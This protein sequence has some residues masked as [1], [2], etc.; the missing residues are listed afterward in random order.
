MSKVN[1]QFEMEDF[2]KLLKGATKGLEELKQRAMLEAMDREIKWKREKEKT[3]RSNIR[4]PDPERPCIYKIDDI[5]SDDEK[6][7]I[8]WNM[9]PSKITLKDIIDQCTSISCKECPFTI[10]PHTSRYGLY[11]C[12]LEYKDKY[13]YR[14]A[15][16]DWEDEDENDPNMKPT[17]ITPIDIIKQC[18]TMPCDECPFGIRIKECHPDIFSPKYSCGLKYKGK[19]IYRLGWVTNRYNDGSWEDDDE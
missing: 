13:I 8:T 12:G 11:K 9:K 14:Y 15:E 19:H 5:D 4:I 16:E 3:D 17:K 6:L 7:N 10:D 18:T 1:V 2:M